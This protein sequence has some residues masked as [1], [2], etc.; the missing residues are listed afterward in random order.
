MDS[1]AVTNVV[2]SKVVKELGVT[3]EGSN[4][5]MNVANGSR[6]GV[7]GTSRASNSMMFS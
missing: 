5:V 2:S 4:R 3:P 1:G 7:L 6:A